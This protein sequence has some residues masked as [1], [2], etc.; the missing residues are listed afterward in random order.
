MTTPDKPRVT[1]IGAGITGLMTALHAYQDY[2]LTVVDAGPDPRKSTHVHGATYSG[3]DA[4]HVSITETTPWTYEYRN[5]LIVEDVTKGGWMCIPAGKLT[6]LEK[7]W[8][9]AFQTHTKDQKGH[10]D[11]TQ[12]VIKMNAEG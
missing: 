6:D 5:E 1:I 8:I 11:T 10:E 2:S 7:Q 3:L 9:T 4:R 12:E